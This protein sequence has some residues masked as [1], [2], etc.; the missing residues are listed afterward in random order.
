MAESPQFQQPLLNP[1]EAAAHEEINAEI[2]NNRPRNNANN[3]NNAN[4]NGNQQPV[5]VPILFRAHVNLIN[6]H[7]LIFF[8]TN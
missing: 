6:F 7:L 5:S 3:T 4:N 8:R 1:Q 2:R